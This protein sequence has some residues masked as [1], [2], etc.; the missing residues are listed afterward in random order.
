MFHNT[1]SYIAAKLYN[2]ESD[3]LLVGSILPDLAVTKVIPWE[4]GLHGKE[5]VEKFYEYIKDKSEYMDL[6]KGIV[7]HNILY[8]FTHLDYGETGYAFQN[9]QELARL[10]G[11]YYGLEEK[12]AISKAH[13]FIESGVDIMLLQDYPSVQEKL[14]K[15]I[16]NTDIKKLADLLAEYFNSDK[17]EFFNMLSKFFSLFT[18]YDFSKKENWSIF[19]IDLEKLMLLKNIGEQKRIELL[20]ESLITV[21]ETYKDFL[22]YSIRRGLKNI[23]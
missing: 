21:G 5:S 19:W 20:N 13:N 2:S 15:A 12:R 4:G 7:A 10:I 18:K 9:N 17:E 14:K 3:L 16:S 8:D 6:Y 11:E 22:E 1:H 23:G